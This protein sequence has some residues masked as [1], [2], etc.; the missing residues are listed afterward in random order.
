M[1]LSLSLVSLS[2]EDP[3]AFSMGCQGVLR[4]PQDPPE[5]ARPGSDV[6]RSTTVWPGSRRSSRPSPR[7]RSRSA[8]STRCRFRNRSTES[9]SGSGIKWM[10]RSCN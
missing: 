6:V 2:G 5:S 8:R 1:A 9:F 4:D 3:S 10:S 7:V